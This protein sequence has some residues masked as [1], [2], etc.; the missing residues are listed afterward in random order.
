[1]AHPAC[2]AGAA[3][4]ATLILAP[5]D[6]EPRH[7]IDAARD[8]QQLNATDGLRA[9]VTAVN[10]VLIARWLGDAVAVRRGFAELACHLRVE[11]M[12][13]PRRLPRLWHV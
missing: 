1:M 8:A 10:G 9:S 11:A 3:A 6:A 2:F 5:R 4:C 13:L 7:H 12:G